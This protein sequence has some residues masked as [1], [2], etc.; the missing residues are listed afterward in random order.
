VGDFG[1]KNFPQ[2]LIPKRLEIIC[3]V[4][5]EI[6]TPWGYRGWGWGSLVV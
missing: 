5:E 3:K 1:E 2:A 4:L 6:Y